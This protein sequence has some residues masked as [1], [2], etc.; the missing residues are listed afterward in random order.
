MNKLPQTMLGLFVILIL[1]MGSASSSY[2][3]PSKKTKQNQKSQPTAVQTQTT[4]A[5]PQKETPKKSDFLEKVGV[6]YLGRVIGPSLGNFGASE[7]T[8]AGAIDT[9]IKLHN[10]LYLSYKFAP[11]WRFRLIPR[12]NLKLGMGLKFSAE[13]IRVRVQNDATIKTKNFVMT[14]YLETRLPTSTT[15][16]DRN[17]IATP[18]IEL[19]P[20]YSFPN[21]RYTLG[22]Y[23][24]AINYW[25]GS[26]GDGTGS[27]VAAYATPWAGYQASPK[28]MPKLYFNLEGGTKRREKLFAG[29]NKNGE[30][31]ANFQPALSWDIT[32]GINLETYLIIPAWFDNDS[33]VKMDTLTIGFDFVGIL[34]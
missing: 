34:F 8:P 1:S 29:W 28:L 26:D 27:L 30:A 33:L 3:K 22:A 25:Y 20:T 23:V 16:H 4:T 17:L 32:K 6:L 15:S 21:S 24:G 5:Q 11:D 31:V 12:W 18:T 13:D 14:T 10:R 19:D 9:P 7:S 2:A